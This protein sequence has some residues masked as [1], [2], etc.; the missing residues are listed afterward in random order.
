MTIGERI[1]AARERAEMTF[2]QVD[3]GAG[4]HKGHTYQI[5]TGRLENPRSDTVEKIARVLGVTVGS[6]FGEP[7]SGIVPTSEEDPTTGTEG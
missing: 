6:L 4:L 5:E 7:D 2:R 3:E 1:R